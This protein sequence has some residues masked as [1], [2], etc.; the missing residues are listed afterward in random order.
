M[1]KQSDVGAFPRRIH[2]AFLPWAQSQPGAIALSDDMLTVRYGELPEAVEAIA[3]QLSAA[4]V[5]AG[6]RVLLV[7]ENSV[8][9]ALC[10]L[11]VSRLDAWSAGPVFRRHLAGGAG[12]R[13][14]EE[15]RSAAVAGDRVHTAGCAQCRDRT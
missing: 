14:G 2:H 11:A 4:G 5:R 8:Q 6:D 9:L 7:A 12:T 10:I 3:A 1:L 13:R 15:C